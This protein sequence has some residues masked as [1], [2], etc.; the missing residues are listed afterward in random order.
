MWQ[1]LLLTTFEFLVLIF[2][3]KYYIDKKR[4]DLFYIGF[5]LICSGV[6]FGCIFYLIQL[7]IDDKLLKPDLDKSIKENL[8]RIK[9]FIYLVPGLLSIIG[10]SVGANLISQYYINKHQKSEN[11]KKYFEN[12]KIDDIF[13]EV[14]SIKKLLYLLIGIIFILLALILFLLIK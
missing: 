2:I 11:Q 8:I 7:G 1:I 9:S 10:T 5:L 13:N 14:K 3:Y 4:N 6:M 12:E